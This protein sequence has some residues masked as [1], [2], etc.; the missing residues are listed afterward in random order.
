MSFE[1][2]NSWTFRSII[3]EH[4]ENK[5]LKILRKVFTS[6]LL[7]VGV[8]LTVENEVVEVF[9]LL[10]FFEWENTLDNDEE[11]DTS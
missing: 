10:S 5:I 11:D 7:P 8:K 9:I 3:R 1:L 4:F 6:D 2:L